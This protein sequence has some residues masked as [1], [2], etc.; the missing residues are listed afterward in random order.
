M[1]KSYLS[2]IEE[3]STLPIKV[4]FDVAEHLV[5]YS[6]VS[7]TREN[8][9]FSCFNGSALCNCYASDHKVWFFDKETVRKNPYLAEFID[10]ELKKQEEWYK[11]HGNE[12]NWEALND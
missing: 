10:I 2:S 1:K 6:E 9:K 11:E 12:V 3:L 5:N 4:Q 7:V 8:G